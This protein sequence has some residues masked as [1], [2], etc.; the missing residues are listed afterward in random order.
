MIFM[1][2]TGVRSDEKGHMFF[3]GILHGFI[4]HDDWH[5]SLRNRSCGVTSS[6]NE[7][8]EFHNDLSCE[9]SDGMEQNVR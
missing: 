5:L 7:D 3:I 4:V 6:L 2:I 9:R 8:K 1:N